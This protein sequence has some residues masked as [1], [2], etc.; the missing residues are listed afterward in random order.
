[1][2]TALLDVQKGIYDKLTND[3]T[4][5]ALVTGVF[6]DVPKTQEFPFIA[7]GPSTETKFNTFTKSGRDI[8]YSIYVYSQY[9]GFKECL[10][11]LERITYLLDYQSITITNNL[12]YIRYDDGSVNLSNIDQGRTKQAEARFRII[13]QE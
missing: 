4:L 5:M 2:E 13:V 10:E 7:I 9:Q 1:M 6:D 8:T 12:V 11:I 3:S